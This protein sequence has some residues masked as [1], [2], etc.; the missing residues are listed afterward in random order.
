LVIDAAGPNRMVIG[1]DV[2]MTLVN[3]ARADASH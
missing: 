1:R 3:I 2:L